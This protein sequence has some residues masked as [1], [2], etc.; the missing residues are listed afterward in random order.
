MQFSKTADPEGVRTVGVLTKAD[1]VKEQAV[2]QTLLQLVKGNTLKLGY[3]IVRNRGADEDA[4]SIA[5]CQ[6]KEKEMFAESRWAELRKLGC[7]GVET[8]RAELQTLLTELA[9]RELPKQKVEVEQRLSKCRRKLE[10]MGPPRDSS[11]SQREC[12]VKLA[13]HFERIARDA[14]DGRYEGNRIFSRYSEL[15][16][17]TKIRELNEG[18]SD[19][20]W[21]KGHAW[22]FVTGSSSQTSRTALNYEK[23]S[24]A[25]QASAS[26]IPELQLVTCD[27]IDCLAASSESIMDHIEKCYRESRGP[28]LGAVRMTR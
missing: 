28:E 19:L 13:S 6:M 7:T 23:K 16:L 27:K 26:S 12:L 14:L 2:V 11:A 9:R 1:L 15:K 21:Q 20:M 17:A 10:F 3:F 18:F 4:L 5:E 24:N 22:E 8:L 25:I